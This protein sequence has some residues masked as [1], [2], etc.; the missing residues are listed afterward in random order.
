MLI[1]THQNG[2]T[3]LSIGIKHQE[4]TE[5]LLQHDADPTP[6]ED[7]DQNILSPLIYSV[8]V[9]SLRSAKLLLE[10]KASVN[11]AN[12]FGQTPLLLSATTGNVK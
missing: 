11:A 4:I 8:E 5:F 6:E 12:Q 1:S 7:G 9:N 2:Y 3:P 10:Y